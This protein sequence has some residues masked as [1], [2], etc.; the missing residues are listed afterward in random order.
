MVR[1]IVIPCLITLLPPVL[2][3]REP[4]PS[5]GSFLDPCRPAPAGF[6][7]KKTVRC[8]FMGSIPVWNEV[9]IL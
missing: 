6:E 5:H 3:Q 9:G 8:A 1:T 4:I 7:G 2:G